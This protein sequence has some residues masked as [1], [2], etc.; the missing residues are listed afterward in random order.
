M[1][2]DYSS[3]DDSSSRTL[4]ARV[5]YRLSHD[6]ALAPSVLLNVRTWDH[7]VYLYGTVSTGSQ[8]D[9]ATAVAAATEGADK[10]KNLLTLSE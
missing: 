10:V 7:I 1:A 2:R 9:L 8:C 4:S 5:S 6:S 3:P